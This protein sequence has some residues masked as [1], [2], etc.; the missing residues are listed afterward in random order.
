MDFG[1][2]EKSLLDLNAAFGAL[3]NCAPYRWQRRLFN[4]YLAR[5]ETPEAHHLLPKIICMVLNGYRQFVPVPRDRQ[6]SR[7][8]APGVTCSCRGRGRG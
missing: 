5:G 7:L 2:D 1:E 3:T 4:E 6:T 8:T